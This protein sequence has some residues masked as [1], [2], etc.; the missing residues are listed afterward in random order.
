MKAFLAC[1]LSMLLSVAVF[2][3]QFTPYLAT[4]NSQQAPVLAA[5][6]EDQY[7]STFLVRGEQVQVYRETRNGFLAIRPL[8]DSYS[9]VAASEL[10]IHADGDH[11][12]VRRAR[13]PSWIGS[14][15]D[16]AVNYGYTVLLDRGEIVTV[17]GQKE[18][19]LSSTSGVQT[20][21][22]IAPPAGEFRWI[23]RQHLEGSSAALQN[24]AQ[25]SSPVNVNSQ[26]DTDSSDI[27]L[28][29]YTD[30]EP[31]SQPLTS[32]RS[33]YV[34]R[35]TKPSGTVNSGKLRDRQRPS[36][37]QPVV[38]PSGSRPFRPVSFAVQSTQGN[39]ADSVASLELAVSEMAT[40]RAESW[41]VG[42]LMDRVNR[43]RSD[44]SAAEQGAL[45]R[46]RDRLLQ[47]Q[48]IKEERQR[49]EA[50]VTTSLPPRS[51]DLNTRKLPFTEADLDSFEVGSG[52][53]TAEA[54]RT[55]YEET[56]YLVRVRSSRNDA[57][58]YALVDAEGEVKAF[59]APQ[60]GLNL[61]TYVRRHVGVFGRRGYLYRLKT[62]YLTVTKI[63]DLDRHKK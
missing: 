33:N 55:A 3:Q 44:S 19:S 7:V 63:V 28:A 2:G 58:E 1:M 40:R 8:H 20:Y 39:V 53:L 62:Q 57:P 45:D 16:R 14:S 18:F 21:I 29:T 23:H 17:L 52:V 9:W 15:D 12:T 37:H 30:L 4:V 60:P 24:S 59:V 10:E 6:F 46:I 32:G 47:Y 11:A 5:P 13:V 51:Y 56:G 50:N 38:D 42:E 36:Q 27:A 49:V 31:G 41:N 26:N 22:K 35:W 43:L 54:R 48:E 25:N 61:S 34:L